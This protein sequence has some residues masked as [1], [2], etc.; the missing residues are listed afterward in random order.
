MPLPKYNG[1]GAYP[2]NE[3]ERRRLL[4]VAALLAML[5][6]PAGAQRVTGPW[7]DATIAPR[8]V[9][10]ISISPRFGQWKERLAA[11]GDR[12]PLGAPFSPDTLGAALPFVS[13][14]APSLAVL[15]GLPSPPL[16]LGSLRTDLDVTE[17]RTHITLD[18]GLTER[19]GLHVL[20]PYVKNRVH[21]RTLPNHGGALPTLGF[22]P[23]HSFNGARQQNELVVSTIGTAATTLSSELTRCLGSVDPSCAAINANRPDAM[24][25]VQ[26]A[27]EVSNAV[28]LVYGTTAAPGGLYAPVAGGALHS[29]VDAR[30]TDLDAQ[31]RAFLG[32]PTS[33]EW[34][35]ARPVP[36]APMAAADL[37]ELL[38]GEASGILARPLGDYEHSHV[39]DIEVGAKFK[40][41][42]TFGPGA[43]AP[44]PRA[45][46][47]RVAVAGVYRLAT[48]QLDLPHDFT[49]VGTGDRQADLELRGFGDLALGP[50]LWV[51]SVLRLGI[52]R[53]D[54]L[55]RRIPDG[56]AQPFLESARELEVGRDLGD[57][58][59]IEFAP[60][61]VPNDEFAVS[62]LYR[63]R[64]KG[65]D[66]YEGTFQ[67][68]SADGT[69][70]SLDAS[71][72]GLGTAQKEH[73][74]GFSVTY[75]TVRGYSR[76]SAKWPL[77]I[78]FLH[79][80]VRSGSGIPRIQMNGIALR[81]YRPVRG[82]SLRP[83]G[84]GARTP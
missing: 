5:G 1:A 75:S 81:L 49:D 43:T 20:V 60:R 71:A 83:A 24:A 69:P 36:A 57:V 27:G 70:L 54:R 19:L 14:L 63:Y 48:G 32:A 65:A 31:F 41:L 11:N 18:Y 78:A 74:L 17:A 22:N 21:V 4:V 84:S 26:L 10:R 46:A 50:R 29:A 58:L 72:L 55:V 52:Q 76:G 51:S 56:A 34:I 9:L 35:A 7:E 62:A 42:D 79:T 61:Y 66:S 44:L 68:T 38:G 45:G 23:A 73:L 8:G 16:S 25:L 80:Q 40:L 67:V 28:A 39:G 2:T 15:T 12:E 47:L 59:E 6:S 64:S 30:L 82:N 33:G 53:P 77:E 13:G 3:P 37:D